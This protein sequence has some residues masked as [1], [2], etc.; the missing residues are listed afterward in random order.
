MADDSLESLRLS[1]MQD[2]LPVGLAMLKRARSGGASKVAEV[3]TDKED[4]LDEL[5]QEGESAAKSVRESLDKLRPGLGN[6]VISVKV[7]VDS[8]TAT[9]DDLEI[10]DDLQIVLNR[11]EDLLNKLED[12]FHSQSQQDT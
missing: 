6:P 10:D 5:R 4:A 11:I 7:D 8:S 1:F 3:F 9:A 12:N 2:F